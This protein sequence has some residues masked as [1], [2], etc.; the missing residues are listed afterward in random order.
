MTNN[1]KLR[2][3]KKT[4]QSNPNHPPTEHPKADFEPIIIDETQKVTFTVIVGGVQPPAKTKA[5]SCPAR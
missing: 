1:H 3:G 5:D 2:P 4:R